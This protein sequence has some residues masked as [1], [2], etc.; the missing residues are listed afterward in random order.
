MRR[1]VISAIMPLLAV[2]FLAVPADAG[3][4][5]CKAD[6]IVRLNGTDV[7]IWV[8][9]PE[10]YQSY[11]NGP[12]DVEVQTPELVTREVI[13]TDAGFNGHGE[14]V[15]FTDLDGTVLSDA[16]PVIIR[17]TV[18]LDRSLLGTEVAVPVQVQAIPDN[19]PALT[20]IGTTALTQVG[21]AVTG[22]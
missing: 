19:G 12:I 3:L 10:E 8:A 22:R 21:L 7:Q 4:I 2:I 20:L 18:P 9:V 13:F 6:P 5:W 11:V 15:R 14:V 1:L 17:V 16:F